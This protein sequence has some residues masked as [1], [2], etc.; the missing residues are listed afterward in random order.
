M[1]GTATPCH[2]PRRGGRGFTL[3]E[4]LVALVLL[5]LFSV[6]SYRALDSVLTAER[7]ASAEMTRWRQ[8]AL[9][10]SR[11]KTDF[12]NAVSGIEARHGG[13][14]GLYAGVNSDGTPY[15]DLDRLLPEDQEGGVQRV[16]YRYHEGQLWRRIWREEAPSTEPPVEAPLLAGLNG[17]GMRYM[18]QT[19]SWHA[20]WVPGGSLG[21][22]PR[23]VEM[24]FRFSAGEPL[25]RVFLLQ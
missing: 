16:G 11:L 10:F 20:S 17:V 4:V 3:L 6:T 14:R 9:A 24:Q 25:R 18:D 19:G 1:M 8:L 22:L 15:L 13:Q 23:A 5:A 2:E 21:A 7:Y 12:A